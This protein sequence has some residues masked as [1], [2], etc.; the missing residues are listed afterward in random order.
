MERE[1][2]YTSDGVPTNPLKG[3]P[4]RCRCGIL[5]AMKK[6]TQLIPEC[7]TLWTLRD[8]KMAP[9]TLRNGGPPELIWICR[10]CDS[11]ER[12]GM[13]RR[14]NYRAELISLDER[15]TWLKSGPDVE[16]GIAQIWSRSM[17]EIRPDAEWGNG[18]NVASADGRMG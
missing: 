18:S 10:C 13:L 6:C 14:K 11:M 2:R 5:I 12:L 15:E 7:K 4:H 8:G 1:R 9:I 17:A 16:R 3:P